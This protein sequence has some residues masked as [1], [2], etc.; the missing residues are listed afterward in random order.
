DFVSGN[1]SPL[2][3]S[4]VTA[5]LSLGAGEDLTAKFLA[6]TVGQKPPQWND[7]WTND[8]KPDDD[9]VTAIASAHCSI[10]A[11]KK[12]NGNVTAALD[13]LRKGDYASAKRPA[14][15]NCTQACPG[16][17][18]CTSDTHECVAPWVAGSVPQP[19]PD[20]GVGSGGGGGGSSNPD[21]GGGGNG[22]G[23]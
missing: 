19:K 8:T 16:E 7:P 1:P 4:Y 3:S 9:A 12:E 10:A 13:S 15:S 2:L 22:T 18:A 21:G 11:A 5:Y 20:A 23:V 6:K 14:P 17:C